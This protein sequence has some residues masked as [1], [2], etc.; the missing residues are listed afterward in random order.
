MKYSN[1][2]SPLSNRPALVI[3]LGSL[4]LVGW[5]FLTMV[6]NSPPSPS[7]VGQTLQ[8]AWPLV[9]N[10]VMQAGLSTAISLLLG[11]LLA[12]ALNFRGSFY[13]RKLFLSLMSAAVVLPSLVVA[14][15]IVSVFGRAGW[16]NQAL[17]LVFTDYK[18]F[19]IYGLSGIVMA[20][21]FFNASLT[22]MVCFNALQSIAIQK[23]KLAA[24]LGFDAWRS[25][26]VLDWPAMRAALIPLSGTIFLLCFTSFAI[27]AMLGGGVNWNTLEVAIYEAVKFEFDLKKAT[28][29]A[30]IQL[31]I[32]AVIVLMW[33]RKPR[34]G[35]T[36]VGQSGHRM[37]IRPQ[38]RPASWISTGIL[39]LYI[40]FLC[41]PLAALIG[42]G[43][44][45]QILN[46]ISSIAVI[47]ATLNSLIIASISAILSTIM[48]F[49]LAQ[50]LVGVTS[51]RESA[52]TTTRIL[53]VLFAFSSMIYLAIPA[54]VLGFG[55]FIIFNRL[56]W[57]EHYGAISA[58]IIANSLASL[59]FA[60]AILFPAIRNVHNRY[61]RL[62]CLTGFSQFQQIKKVLWPLL[63]GQ[64][65]WVMALVF[66]FSLGDYGVIA[67][68]GG[69]HLTTL[70]L[71]MVRNFGSYRTTIAA[72]IAVELLFI[73][74]TIFFL[75]QW[76]AHRNDPGVT[77]H[78]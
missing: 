24:A 67:L 9:R 19:S 50:G 69:D 11:V 14:L 46:I 65:L 40:F 28:G 47:S 17:G 42:S 45:P 6:Q 58:V 32:S 12:W 57:V 41:T 43:L 3:S 51:D 26:W 48:A 36:M 23:R 76:F 5:I 63:K 37:N 61:E 39:L 18:P 25:F 27:V 7:S 38:S 4:G 35:S 53:Q 66:C 31:L 20:H 59:P 54:L 62:I 1:R 8:A 30:L 56:N 78:G 33:A 60:V 13:F 29:L 70:P 71:L 16:V 2:Q 49:F 68:F 44:N 75:A 52:T 34:S 22:A 72:N 74:A 77:N 15:A 10:T 55:M 64:L 73:V 21:V